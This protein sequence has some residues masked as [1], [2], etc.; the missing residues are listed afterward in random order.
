LIIKYFV[1]LKI[2]SILYKF[3]VDKISQI[4]RS[5]NMRQI[6][7]KNSKLELIVRKHLHNLGY[8]YTLHKKQI[9]G[10]PDLYLRKYNLAVFINGCFWHHHGCGYYRLPKSN[11]K[12]WQE[13]LDKNKKRDL[14]I[15]G[16]L[17]KKK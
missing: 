9:P 3:M 1:E 8:R 7:N 14:K 12:F 11:I 6:K 5:H 17:S 15:K 13:K 10:K 4:R 16:E 2:N